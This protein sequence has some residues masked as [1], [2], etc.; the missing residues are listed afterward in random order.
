M[1]ERVAAA[2]DKVVEVREQSDLEIAQLSRD[3]EI[4]IA[5]D[6]GGLTSGN[7]PGIFAFRAAPIQLSYVGY[8]GTMAACY[9]E[10]LIADK[11]II[12]P[13][14]QKYYPE[15]IAYLPSYQASPL[16]RSVSEKTIS[17]SELG[18][19]SAGFVFCCFNNNIKI[20][21]STFDG[22]MRILKKVE[23]SVLFLYAGNTLAMTNLK[24]EAAVRGVDPSRLIFGEKLSLP[25]HLSRYRAADL[26]L[27]TLPYNAGTTAS[28]A[29]WAGVPVLT[30]M[31]ESFASRIAGSV[32]NAIQLPE[33]ITLS[34]EEYE[35]RA[36]ELA[37]NP[38]MLTTIRKKLE[39]NRSTTALFNSQSLAKHMEAAYTTMYE[40]YH[41]GLPPD[42]I[43]SFF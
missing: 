2:F 37:K 29:L 28:D 32:L 21:P 30:C 15:K 41:M 25:E 20:T 4:D 12:P 27:D 23:G 10:Y 26:F 14:L 5:V 38:E 43:E 6:L 9:Y 22:W 24:T 36:I 8:L 34:Q 3:L 31:G 42:H 33:L 13:T 17:K 19:P 40:R 1:S 35:V 39:K 18:L 16:E 7:R 11:T